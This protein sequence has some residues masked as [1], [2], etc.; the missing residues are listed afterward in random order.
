MNFAAPSGNG[1]GITFGKKLDLSAK[2]QHN[3]TRYGKILKRGGEVH[4]KTDNKDLFEFSLNS[5]SDYG[6]K[7]KNI[8]L[9]LNGHT[10]TTAS[11]ITVASGGTL[12]ITGDGKYGDIKLNEALRKKYQLRF[13]LLHA[14]RLIWKQKEGKLSYL[15][16][17]E[18]LAPNPKIFEKIEKDL[19]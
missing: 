3:R 7:L 16:G 15:A 1:R 8:T 2:K 14:Y 11:T 4:F 5:F 13:Q 17:K 6:L 10:I 19:F 18:F 9:D 12:N